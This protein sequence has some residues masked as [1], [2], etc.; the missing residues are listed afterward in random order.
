MPLLQIVYTSALVD[1]DPAVI[2]AMQES[3]QR[4]NELRNITGMLLLSTGTV[5]QVLEGEEDNVLKTFRAIE[6]DMRH[7]HVHVLSRNKVPAR[8]FASLPMG[9][10]AV[11]SSGFGDFPF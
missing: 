7:Q 1:D 10:S 2:A 6:S 4:I 8:Q 9:F 11:S 5:L 3:S